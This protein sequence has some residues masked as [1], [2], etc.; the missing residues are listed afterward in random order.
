MRIV[1]SFSFVFSRSCLQRSPRL[2]SWWGGAGCP[3]PRIHPPLSALWASFLGVSGSNRVT[4][5]ATLLMIYFKCRPIWSLY[6][7]SFRENGLGSEEADGAMLPPRYLGLEPPLA[8]F[9]QLLQPVFPKVDF[10]KLSEE[11]T[12]VL[13]LILMLTLDSESYQCN[14]A[15]IYKQCLAIV[16]VL[17]CVCIVV[18]L[19]QI[20]VLFENFD[21]WTR[22]AGPQTLL[23]LLLLLL[24]LLLLFFF[25]FFFF[26]F[27]ESVP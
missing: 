20:T 5:L 10:W 4:G 11:T 2:P 21:F 14:E 22:K 6:F 7:F 1:T 16:C 23:W 17:W 9:P 8:S 25:F 15:L 24:L 26:L 3:L 13:V 19:N 18:K 27:L 12:S